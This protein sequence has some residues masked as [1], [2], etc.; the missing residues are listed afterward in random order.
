MALPLLTVVPGSILA[1]EREKRGL[2]Q[3]LEARGSSASPVTESEHAGQG[4][5]TA[6]L[7]EGA[8]HVMA[9]QFSLN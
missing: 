5:V 3:H 9:I 2:P 7:R 1:A 4:A 6:H 8:R